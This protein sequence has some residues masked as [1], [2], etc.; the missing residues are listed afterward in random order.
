LP[1]TTASSRRFSAGSFLV[2]SKPRVRTAVSA[3]ARRRPA[4]RADPDGGNRARGAE[5]V[6]R[7]R[8]ETPRGRRPLRRALLRRLQ[9]GRAKRR[10]PVDATIIGLVDV[11][12][13]WSE[14]LSRRFRAARRR[15][16]WAHGTIPPRTSSCTGFRSYA[17]PRRRTASRPS[18]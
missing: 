12:S 16:L 11:A 5:I 17:G 13:A 2:K 9:R 1:N 10:T 15:F 18:V 7:P 6:K 14:P 3:S 8:P 4:G